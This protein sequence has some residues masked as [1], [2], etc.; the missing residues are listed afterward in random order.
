MNRLTP[1]L[2]IAL[3]TGFELGIIAPEVIPSAHAQDAETTKD[4]DATDSKP[5]VET[6]IHKTDA[7]WRK[8]LTTDQYMVTRLKETEPP[9]SGRFSRGHYNGTFVCVCCQAEL[10]TSKTKFDSGTGWPSFW[11]PIR[12]DAVATQWD[13]STGQPRVE[14]MCRRCDAHLGH[15]FDDGP[16]P[17]GLR[18]CMN[19][20]SLKFRPASK[21]TT[22]KGKSKSKSTEKNSKNEVQIDRE[23][24]EERKMRGNEGI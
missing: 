11:R 14:V 17:T 8:I 10:F 5:P 24:F 12:K 7:E 6:K 18:Y 13:Y 1:L 16:R 9:F 2:A 15:V 4:K 23:K 19:S 22:S 21:G 20:L 3:V